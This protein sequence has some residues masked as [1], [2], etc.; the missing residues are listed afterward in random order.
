MPKMCEHCQTTTG[1]MY[2]KT[3]VNGVWVL[4]CWKCRNKLT[5]ERGGYD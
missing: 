4:L 3:L 1:L 2:S 5:R